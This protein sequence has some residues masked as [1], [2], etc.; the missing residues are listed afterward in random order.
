[1]ANIQNAILEILAKETNPAK[2]PRL[3]PEII[4]MI[5]ERLVALKKREVPPEHLVIRLTLSRELDNYSVLSAPVIAAR[6]LE[7]QGKKLGRGQT[8]RFIHTA[9]APAVRAWDLPT[10]FDPCEIDVPKYRELTVFAAYE[11]LQ[12][13]GITERIL[14]DW[15]LNKASYVRPKDLTN[16]SKRSAKQIVPLLADISDLHLDII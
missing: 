2:L 1:V 3:L 11:V 9:K 15:I 5:D 10:E 7:A 14:R 8:I 16:S 4:K 13:L 6:Q 12:P